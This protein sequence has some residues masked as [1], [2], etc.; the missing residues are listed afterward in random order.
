MNNGNSRHRRFMLRLALAGAVTIASCSLV[1]A[2]GSSGKSKAGEAT[3]ADLYS[4]RC[5]QCHSERYAK[6]RTSAQW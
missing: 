4:A 2:A 1:I 5:S 6:E 3:G